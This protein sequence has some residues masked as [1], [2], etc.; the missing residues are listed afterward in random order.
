[1]RRMEAIGYSNLDSV[2]DDEVT[3]STLDSEAIEVVEDSKRWFFLE[4][5]FSQ[6]PSIYFQQLSIPTSS[7]PPIHTCDV[8]NA[9]AW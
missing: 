7:W 4:Q 2:V 5:S 3:L 1:M 6:T 8:D 9:N